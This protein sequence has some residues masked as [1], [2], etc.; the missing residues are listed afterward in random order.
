M[1]AFAP[2]LD[3]DWDDAEAWL[4]A[5]TARRRPQMIA[6]PDFYTTH[7][8]FFAHSWE[9]AE[10]ISRDANRI[11]SAFLTDEIT[12]KRAARRELLKQ[13]VIEETA[14]GAAKRQEAITREEA[15]R[16][17]RRREAEEA[18]ARRAEASTREIER[19]HILAE[20]WGCAE[21]LG[22]AVVYPE[23][24]KYKLVCYQCKRE[25]IVEHERIMVVMR[26]SR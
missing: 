18:L 2:L 1:I 22:P 8:S 3:P 17:E 20:N 25:A 12:A 19:A 6:T 7:V 16:A 11:H 23:G 5:V 9:D 15:K 10:R 24:E 14:L 21:C 26:A 13:A 4:V